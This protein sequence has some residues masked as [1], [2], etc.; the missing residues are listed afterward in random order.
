MLCT[1]TTETMSNNKPCAVRFKLYILTY[2]T[3]IYIT[4]EKLCKSRFNSIKRKFVKS[5][6]PEIICEKH[7]S[8]LDFPIV[9]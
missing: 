7:T 9:T 5:G 4:N 2:N 8:V 3:Y 6:I 1:V